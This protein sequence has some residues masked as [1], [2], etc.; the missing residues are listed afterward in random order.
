MSSDTVDTTEDVAFAKLSESLRVYLNPDV[1]AAQ[2][3]RGLRLVGLE[4]HIEG[5]KG[6]AIVRRSQGGRRL[7]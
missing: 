7:N 4:A 2:F 5:G 6:L 3:A 1:S